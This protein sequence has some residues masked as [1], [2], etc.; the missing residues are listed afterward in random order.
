MSE[1]LKTEIEETEE[2]NE[3]GAE[4]FTN[5]SDASEELESFRKNSL[6]KRVVAWIFL[7]LIAIMLCIFVY[8]V[9]TGSI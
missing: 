2:I 4:E 6:F 1:E 3:E 9:F 8:M 7:A 5:E